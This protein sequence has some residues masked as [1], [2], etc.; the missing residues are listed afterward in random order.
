M[1]PDE[2]KAEIQRRLDQ[3]PNKKI[4]YLDV[5]E[6]ISVERIC[7]WLNETRKQLIGCYGRWM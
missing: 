4:Y 3:I 6:N 5:P 2:E 7:V 1:T